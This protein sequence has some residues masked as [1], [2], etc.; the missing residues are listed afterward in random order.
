MVRRTPLNPKAAPP[1]IGRLT[2]IQYTRIAA[3]AA[4]APITVKRMYEGCRSEA[5][6]RERVSQSAASLGLPLPPPANETE[7][8]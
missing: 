4:V 7:V 2:S 1:P 6:T 8:A 5:T 3:A